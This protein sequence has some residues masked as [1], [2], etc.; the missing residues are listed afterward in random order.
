MLFFQVRAVIKSRL[1]GWRE[2]RKVSA[3]YA[4]AS[5]TNVEIRVI[6]N[7]RRESDSRSDSGHNEGGEVPPA[8]PVAASVRPPAANHPVNSQR[9]TDQRM[10]DFIRESGSRTITMKAIRFKKRSEENV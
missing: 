9:R 1:R 2:N 6:G 4:R 8:A 10:P 7:D 3:H 5:S